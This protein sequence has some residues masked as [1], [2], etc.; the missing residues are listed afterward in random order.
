[1]L[2]FAGIMHAGVE[3]RTPIIKNNLANY[4]MIEPL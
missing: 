1:M 4:I 3:V 2:S